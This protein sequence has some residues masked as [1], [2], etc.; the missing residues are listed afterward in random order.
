ML[1][2][3][4]GS[5]QKYKNVL[6]SAA[7]MVMYEVFRVICRMSHSAICS[8]NRTIVTRNEN[9]KF[10][11]PVPE[12]KK[13]GVATMCE[14]LVNEQRREREHMCLQSAYMMIPSGMRCSRKQVCFARTRGLVRCPC[15]RLLQ[16]IGWIDRPA[17]PPTGLGP[18]GSPPKL[19]TSCSGDIIAYDDACKSIVL[20]AV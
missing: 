9:I 19:D 13:L 17:L 20:C 3:S 8:M 16:T 15:P 18:E 5:D 2:R 14:C 11:L 4:R 6:L 10:I 12:C 1:P 7:L